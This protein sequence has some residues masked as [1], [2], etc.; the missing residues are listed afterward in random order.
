MGGMKLCRRNTTVFD[1]QAYL[2]EEEKLLNGL[3][4]GNTKPRYADPV[5]YRGNISAPSG[6][7]VNSLFGQDIRYTHVLV[8]DDPNADIAE[9]G[10]VR[11]KDSEYDI[12]AVRP[13]INV[14]TVALKKRTKNHEAG[15]AP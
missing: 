9:N 10:L 13:S 11:W 4:T 3:H 14:L 7:V 5:P 12:T 1:Y 15:D 6:S 2:G 8:M